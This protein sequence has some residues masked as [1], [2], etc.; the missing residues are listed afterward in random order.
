MPGNEAL[1]TS[2]DQRASTH[3]VPPRAADLPR[4][5]VKWVDYAKGFCIIFVV[6][7]HSVLGVE[8]AFGEPGW[9]HVLV[10]F[11]KPFRMPD[12]FMISGLFLGLVI[13]RPWRRYLDRRGVHFFY[14]YALWVTIQFAFKAPMWLGEGM[15]A[16]GLAGQWLFAFVEPFG[17][18]WFIYI[19]PVFAI[20]TRLTRPV[21]WPALLA[22]AATLEILPIHTGWTMIDEFA[23]RYVYFL[24][25]Y[26]FATRIFA[27]ADWAT[28]NRLATLGL[29]AGWIAVNG[30]LTFT[31]APAALLA[32]LGAPDG[33]AFISDLPFVSLMLGAGGAVGVILTT[34][35]LSTVSWT[36]FLA[37][38]G[39]N[40][41]V[42][43]LAF[44]LPMA[45]T[46]TV[47]VKLVPGLGIGTISLIVTV[48]GVIGPVILFYLVN[49]TGYGR[50]L[51]ERPGWARLD[52][53]RAAPPVA[54][55]LSPAE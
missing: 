38:L 41:I 22:V 14:F 3:S 33:M 55:G 29:L 7:M 51:F 6:M 46:R 34:T 32:W 11:A 30:A 40:S 53:R 8:K 23:W 31:P 13:V 35:L 20:V 42:V 43:Y 5:R 37:W 15:S 4:G 45:I 47:L 24:S 48:A 9:M 27:F 39:R 21:P 52:G 50:F 54:P 26:L 10:Q 44:F 19:L 16:P 18:L 49:R 12:F 36:A 17:T 25:G 1:T 28:R 2:A